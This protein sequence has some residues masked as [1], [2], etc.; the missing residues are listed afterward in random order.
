M[1]ISTLGFSFED[2][3]FTFLELLCACTMFVCAC[4][5]VLLHE[6]IQVKPLLQCALIYPLENLVT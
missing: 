6:N 5:C 2:S 1:W 3:N 4:T